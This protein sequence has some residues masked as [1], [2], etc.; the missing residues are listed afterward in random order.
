MQVLAFSATYTPELQQKI[1]SLMHRPQRVLLAS[2]TTSLLG[3]RQF[4]RLVPCERA[5][6][7]SCSFLFFAV[8]MADG[9]QSVFLTTGVS[10]EDT[11]LASL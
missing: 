8:P 5:A 7:D 9:T 2:R 3:V 4:Y 11:H 1:E 6:P 10:R